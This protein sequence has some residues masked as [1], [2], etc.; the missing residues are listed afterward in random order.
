V[1]LFTAKSLR[2]ANLAVSILAFVDYRT[3]IFEESNEEIARNR[4]ALE[5]AAIPIQM[6]RCR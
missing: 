3:I 1:L 6:K 4:K 5:S 2:A